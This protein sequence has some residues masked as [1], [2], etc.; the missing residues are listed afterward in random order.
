MGVF[1]F[2]SD[3]DMGREKRMRQDDDIQIVNLLFARQESGLK[4]LE[5]KYNKYCLTIAN[6]ILFDNEDSKECVN[7]AWLKIWNS[8]PPN[9]PENLAGYLA[10][11]VRNLALNCYEKKHAAK[12]GGGQVE[13]SYDELSECMAG[14]GRVDENL[15]KNELSCIISKFL[16]QK[17]EQKRTIFIQRYFYFAEIS[18]IADRMGMK[19]SSVRSVLSR[20]RKELKNYLEQ[21]GIA[22]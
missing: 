12:R 2:K 16:K 4:K 22:I 9:R 17:G 1:H 21:E 18:D 14:K 13:M 15:E 7:D 10:K 3:Y 6:R 20:M 19:E 11:I 5:E 8:I